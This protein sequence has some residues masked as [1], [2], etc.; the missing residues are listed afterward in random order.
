[1]IN[2]IKGLIPENENRERAIG[3]GQTFFSTGSRGEKEGVRSWEENQMY[4]VISWLFQ[5]M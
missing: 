1:M 4:H 5:E 3:P 2:T